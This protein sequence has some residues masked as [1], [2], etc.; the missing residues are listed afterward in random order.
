[1][2]EGFSRKAMSFAAEHEKT[3]GYELT[4]DTAEEWTTTNRGHY[5]AAGVGGSRLR[6]DH[7]VGISA[8]ERSPMTPGFNPLRHYHIDAMR[9]QPARFI[10]SCRGRQHTATGGFYPPLWSRRA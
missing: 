5:R 3:L 6:C 2:A 9:L 8:E 10:N 1:M 7:G 4:R